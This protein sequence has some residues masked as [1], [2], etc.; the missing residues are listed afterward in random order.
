MDTVEKE[1]SVN[2]YVFIGF[3]IFFVI[4]I[5]AMCY[6]NVG[7]KNV[8]VNNTYS[9][10][11][12]VTTNQAGLFYSKINTQINTLKSIENKFRKI[13]FDD[14]NELKN[15]IC[16][17]DGFGE[18]KLISIADD[19]GLAIGN[20]NTMVG[21]IYRTDYYRNAM[22][23]KI[24]VS[25]KVLVDSE[26]EDVIALSVPVYSG[27]EVKGVLTG[28]FNEKT[29]SSLFNSKILD[30]NG[31]SCIVDSDGDIIAASNNDKGM[32]K[33][34]NI[35]D[36]LDRMKLSE[37]EDYKE[38]ERALRKG[39]SGMFD[40]NEQDI[41]KYVCYHPVGVCDWYVMIIVTDEVIDK[42][43]NPVYILVLALVVCV[44]ALF[45]AFI[46]LLY[47]VNFNKHQA[48]AENNEKA[49][50]DR[51]LNTDYN[52]IEMFI[53]HDGE[54]DNLTGVYNKSNFAISVKSYLERNYCN[55]KS[56][57][58]V[59]DMADFAEI[60]DNLGHSY[61]D[62]VLAMAV[63]KIQKIFYEEDY[64]G[65]VGGDVFAVLMKLDNKFDDE[66]LVDLIERKVI[67]VSSSIKEITY[68]IGKQTECLLVTTGVSWCP[69]DGT[70]YI[71]LYRHADEALEGAKKKGKGSYMFYSDLE[72]EYI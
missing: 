25:D 47:R 8:T 6:F 64:I 36:Y 11:E 37:D 40:Y 9:F 1:I 56:V 22:S 52:Y 19:T 3:G 34:K 70:D 66:K 53:K 48:E 43:T 62:A 14:Y 30:G 45:L 67:Q 17:T 23:G 60:N 38:L 72:K 68:K 7:I 18:F 33:E 42:Q 13:S 57:L 26:G 16:S 44:A 65:R 12:E 24:S 41:Q 39:Q 61:G 21:N 32:I 27:S 5:V 46:V 35:F 10:L 4:F 2:K 49:D 50:A 28:I 58:F 63:M 59:F 71:R 29:L 20:N 51:S 69:Q 55:N 54:N 15:T 31:Y